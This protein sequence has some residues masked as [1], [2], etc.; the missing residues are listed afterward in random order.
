MQRPELASANFYSGKMAG[1]Y[2]NQTTNRLQII[3]Q[4][5]V[6]MLTE[7]AANRFKWEN[8]PDDINPRFIELELL[9]N[10]RVIFFRS[11]KFD[12]YM[13]LRGSG[14][15]WWDYQNDPTFYTVTGNQAFSGTLSADDCVP[16]WSNYMR[17][18]DS[19][20]VYLYASKLAEM[21]MTI[22]VNSKS[23]RLTKVV[24]AAKNARLSKVNI[25]RKVEQGEP[26]IWATDDFDP[27]S[28]G[29]LDLGVNPDNII[30]MQTAKSKVWNE[31]MT[32]LGINNANQDKKERL[33][34]D[35]VSANDDQVNAHRA[36]ALNER[37]AAVEK[38]NGKYGLDI[39]V[40]FATD[41]QHLE[42]ME[43]FG[44][45][46]ESGQEEAEEESDDENT[47]K[48]DLNDKKNDGE[49][50]ENE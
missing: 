16:I 35:E 42:Q 24:A 36:I 13:A 41:H 21:D 40:G 1:G 25:M 15:G 31:A 48:A 2:N 28:I 23:A 12:K 37:R 29:L 43:M 9:Y 8:L 11:D 7:L 17:T 10:G 3:E 38:I 22:E 4:M 44:S 20:I 26:I 39:S 6:R 5:Y 27:S 14:S 19:D 45:F 33:V 30:S 47:D 46:D 34:A 49:V 50:K 18:G 32:M